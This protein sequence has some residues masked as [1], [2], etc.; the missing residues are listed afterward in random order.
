METQR[1]TIMETIEN[2]MV[3]TRPNTVFHYHVKLSRADQTLL[4]MT[5]IFFVLVVSLLKD[6]VTT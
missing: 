3:M 6:D 1:E 2:L 4:I 5:I